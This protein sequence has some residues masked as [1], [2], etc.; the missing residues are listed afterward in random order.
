MV[1]IWNTL[2]EELVSGLRP[3]EGLLRSLV[4][5]RLRGSYANRPSS[6][7]AFTLS[8]PRLSGALK[9]LRVVGN[10]QGGNVELVL[11]RHRCA[12][13]HS[14]DAAGAFLRVAVQIRSEH[15]RNNEPSLEELSRADSD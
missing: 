6:L 7:S 3:T 8:L 14:P 4:L 11:R 5:G 12:S 2:S 15:S 1:G 13:R 10:R 9:G